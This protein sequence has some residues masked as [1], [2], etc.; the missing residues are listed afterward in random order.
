MDVIK[1][2]R[3]TQRT[4]KIIPAIRDASIDIKTIGRARSGIT[5]LEKRA[6]FGTC[7]FSARLRYRA[8]SRV[9]FN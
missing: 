7:F 4:G 3:D 2:N 8:V 1:Y 6:N 5:A 9:S